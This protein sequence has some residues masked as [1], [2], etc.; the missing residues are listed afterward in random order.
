MEPISTQNHF[1]VINQENL[2][3]LH[4][5]TILMPKLLGHDVRLAYHGSIKEE[6]ISK[7]NY[8]SYLDMVASNL[9]RLQD[10]I[11]GDC[12][13]AKRFQ[14]LDSQIPRNTKVLGRVG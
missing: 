10:H 7:P 11:K 14:Q 1:A 3:L 5:G 4:V 13:E 2:S 8:Q 12:G 6:R 9:S